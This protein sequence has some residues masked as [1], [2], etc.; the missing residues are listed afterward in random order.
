MSLLKTKHKTKILREWSKTNDLSSLKPSNSKGKYISHSFNDIRVASVEYTK[1]VVGTTYIDFK[2]GARVVEME[3]GGC[4]N[5]V[6]TSVA[7]NNNILYGI[8][9]SSGSTLGLEATTGA[10]AEKMKQL[11]YYDFVPIS[12]CIHRGNIKKNM[13]MFY[14]DKELGR[15]AVKNTIGNKIL[16]GEIGGGVGA[17]YGQGCSYGVY[18]GNKILV[19]LVNN[20]V[21]SIYKNGK[22]FKGKKT[23][24]STNKNKNTK[25]KKKKV[26]KK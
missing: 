18:K 20:A 17:K 22:H 1:A 13:S 9:L 12:G 8:C 25:I 10:I 11:N 26:K 24:K 3:Y 16:Y 7:C 19:I 15:Y 23:Y 5:K 4:V 2:N 6:S 21:G 14:P